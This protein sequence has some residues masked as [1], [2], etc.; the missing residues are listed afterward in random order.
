MSTL[1]VGAGTLL[2][3]AVEAADDVPAV[4]ERAP[5]TGE[6]RPALPPQSEGVEG[7]PGSAAVARRFRRAFIATAGQTAGGIRLGVYL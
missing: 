3:H 1:I 2:Q 4:P 5:T 7:C 6:S